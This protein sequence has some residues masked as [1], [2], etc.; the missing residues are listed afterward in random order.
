MY[1]QLNI[2]AFLL[3]ILFIIA[4]I[5]KINGFNS[6]VDGFANVLTNFNISLPFM[7]MYQL[8]I[9]LVIILEICAPFTILLSINNFIDRYYGKVA[10]VLIILFTIL[11]TFLYHNPLMDSTQTMAMLKNLSIIGGLGCLHNLL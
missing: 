11:A 9:L 2:S 6:T 4:G 10:T 7:Q 8:I 5:N 3:V 1:N